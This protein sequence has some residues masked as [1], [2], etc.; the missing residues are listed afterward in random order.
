MKTI[1]FSHSIKIMSSIAS[2]MH[3][4]T[5]Q[6]L[7]QEIDQEVIRVFPSIYEGI[8]HSMRRNE[9]CHRLS[10]YSHPTAVIARLRNEGFTVSEI[11]EH[12]G[13]GRSDSQTCVTITWPTDVTHPLDTM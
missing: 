9:K 12:L 1:K 5:M 13:D 7:A 10:I 6:E 2:E 8:K 3:R 11:T 4:K